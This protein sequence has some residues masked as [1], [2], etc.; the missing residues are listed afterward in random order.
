MR[1]TRV[2]FIDEA[3][4]IALGRPASIMLQQLEVLKSFATTCEVHLVLCGPYQLMSS[5][6]LNPQ[7]ARRI[8]VVHFP[9]YTNDADDLQNFYN[10]LCALVGRMA[11][12]SVDMDLEKDV[13]FFFKR[14]L[15]CIGILKPWL[16]RAAKRAMEEGS[17]VITRKML[18]GTSKNAKDFKRLEGLGR[19][20]RIGPRAEEPANGKWETKGPP[21]RRTCS[22]ARPCWRE[23]CSYRTLNGPG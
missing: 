18:E 8:T 12:W 17:A 1:N 2:I 5:I 9:R 7:L 10:A 6:S 21:S 19:L 15:G 13:L 20:P 4:H 11:P 23:R 3:H 14:S 22:R 16:D